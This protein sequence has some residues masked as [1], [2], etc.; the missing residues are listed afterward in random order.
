MA[1]ALIAVLS[2]MALLFTLPVTAATAT[3]QEPPQWSQLTPQQQ[4]IL[5]PLKNDWDGFKPQRRKK[6][7]GIAKRYPALAPEKQQR[8]QSRMKRWASLTP[9]ER[10]AARARFRKRD[11]K[12]P[13]QREAHRNKWEQY[14]ALPES[15]KRKFR[16]T[17][18]RKSPRRSDR[19]HPAPR[20][21]LSPVP[22]VPA[23]SG[24][25]DTK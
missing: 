17:P 3:S 15:E 4:A 2:A 13:E 25:T 1:S 16:E 21:L 11:R 20:P 14:Q 8:I 5:A 19:D 10:N 24:I 6:W 18:A 7:L 22:A 23:P 9:E 12:T